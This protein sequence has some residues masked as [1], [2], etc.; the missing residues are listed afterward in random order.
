MLRLGLEVALPKANNPDP[1][2]KDFVH[3]GTQNFY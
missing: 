2:S 1:N 3:S